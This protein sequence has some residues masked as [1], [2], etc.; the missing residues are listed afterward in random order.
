MN[1]RFAGSD[2]KQSV[3]LTGNL[4]SNSAN[5]LVSRRSTGKA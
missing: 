3:A 2:G 5:A 1:G 4:Q